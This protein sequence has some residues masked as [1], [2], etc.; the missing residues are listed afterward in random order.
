[1][2]TSCL[3]LF[4]IVVGVNLL[5]AFGPPTWSIIVVYELNSTIP[6]PVLVLTGASAAAIGRF[7]LAH[8]FRLLRGHIPK[9]MARNVATAGEQLEKRKRHTVLALGL[10]VLSP[11]PSAQLFEAAGLTR[12]RLL[13]FTAAFFVGRVV[14]YSIYAAGAKGIEKS[15]I[16]DTFVHSLTSPVGIAVQVFMIL[17]LVG[18]TLVDW[19]K[20]FGE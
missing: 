8:G 19:E 6:L 3:I 12:I 18:L 11:V 9:K 2:L 1:M 4:A 5:P 17:L 15:S 13:P 20:R 7:A 10:F 14:S 16:G